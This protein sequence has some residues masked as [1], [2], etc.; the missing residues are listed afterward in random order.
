MARPS[1]YEGSGVKLSFPVSGELRFSRQLLLPT[2]Y[3]VGS[4]IQD[5]DPGIREREFA[6]AVPF[7]A[8][9]P[10]RVLDT[11]RPPTLD[12][13]WS[14]DERLCYAIFIFAP[15]GMTPSLA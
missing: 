14:E 7:C 5:H 9:A 13:R 3:P 10:L 4:L 6:S 12:R 11:L 15:S 8:T 2:S 1:S